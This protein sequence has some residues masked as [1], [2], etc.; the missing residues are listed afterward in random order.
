MSRVAILQSATLAMSDARLEYYLQLAATSKAG[1]VLMGEYVIN[2]FFTELIKMPPSMI[3]EQSEQKRASLSVFAKKYNL[4]IIAPIIV[5]KNR[6]MSKCVA[7]F[8]PSGVKTVAQNQLINYAHWDEAKFFD[9]SEVA[10]EF[11]RFG[12]DGFRFAVMMGFEAH[13][14]RLWMELVSKKTDCVL[15]PTACTLNSKA[16]WDALLS[17]RAFCANTY[18]LRAN[19][20]GSAVFRDKAQEIKSEFYGHSMMISPHGEILQTLDSNEGLMLCELDKKLLSEARALWK[21]T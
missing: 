12:Y 3:K 7:K 6:T 19:R 5:V 4:I 8:S 18:L 2:S 17:S 9:N 10:T 20:L 13:F 1:V 15:M 16:R 11:L 14:D 21:F